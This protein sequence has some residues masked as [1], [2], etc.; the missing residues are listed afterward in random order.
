MEPIGGIKEKKINWVKVII[1]VIILLAI[2]GALVYF[3]VIKNLMT[4]ESTIPE[5]L[6]SGKH[7]FIDNTNSICLDVPPKYN[8]YEFDSNTGHVLELKST[9]D[10]CVLVTYESLFTSEDKIIDF[11]SKDR[12][13]YL[14]N[15][16]EPSNVSEIQEGTIK[17]NTKIYFYSFDY[18]KSRKTYTLETI[19][20]TNDYGYYIID[21]N[22]LKPSEKEINKYESLHSD[23]LGGFSFVDST[24]EEATEAEPVSE[25]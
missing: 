8:L 24:N 22:Y 9:D 1:A 17:D 19:W 14:T 25:N 15:Y 21:I 13:L 23:I 5:I 12:D 11:I 20:I 7:V 2:I 10:L 3:L 6:K 18:I 4:T 16:N